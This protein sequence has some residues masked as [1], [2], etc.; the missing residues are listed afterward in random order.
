MRR[1][2]GA[3]TRNSGWE[4]STASIVVTEQSVVIHQGD[5]FW[6]EITPRSTRECEVARD[7]DRIQIRAGSGASATSWSFRPPADAEG[8]AEDV[9]AVISGTAGAKRR[10]RDG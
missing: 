5:Y 7:H 9:R 3:G 6:L 4:E 2:H 8:W 10:A 1:T